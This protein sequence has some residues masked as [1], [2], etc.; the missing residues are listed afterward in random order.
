MKKE[1]NQFVLDFCEGI[2]C[3]LWETNKITRYVDC[4]LVDVLQLDSV[5]DIDNSL[6]NDIMTQMVDVLNNT[7]GIKAYIASSNEITAYKED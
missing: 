4:E 3:A 2:E 1:L 6:L 5:N 7:E